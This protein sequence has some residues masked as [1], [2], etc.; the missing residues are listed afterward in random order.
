MSQSTSSLGVSWITMRPLFMI[1]GYT[2]NSCGK[3]SPWH[4]APRQVD[5]FQSIR[6]RQ[7]AHGDL[8][9]LVGANAHNAKLVAKTGATLAANTA[10]G[11]NIR[12]HFGAKS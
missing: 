3:W 8:H 5:K 9:R 1:S 6:Q 2:A 4:E 11:P 10:R 12:S 7:A